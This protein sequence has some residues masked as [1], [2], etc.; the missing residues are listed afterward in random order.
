MQFEELN[1]FLA[2]KKQ[3]GSINRLKQQN[4][5][6]ITKIFHNLNFSLGHLA[7]FL[8]KIM[9]KVAKWGF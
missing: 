6:Q 9:F 7:N 3:M 5:G 4:G 1:P 2:I 8:H